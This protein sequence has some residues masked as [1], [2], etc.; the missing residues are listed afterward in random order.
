MRPSLVTYPSETPLRPC[1]RFKRYQQK[2][3]QDYSE[4]PDKEEGSNY[5]SAINPG[6]FTGSPERELLRR[7]QD[8]CIDGRLVCPGIQ[9]AAD[10]YISALNHAYMKGV[11]I[12]NVLKTRSTR[13]VTT[14]P[15]AREYVEETCTEGTSPSTPLPVS[16]CCNVFMPTVRRISPQIARCGPFMRHSEM[17][18]EPTPIKR[19]RP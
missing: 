3:W 11:P 10:A 12:T 8:S 14:Y 2:D 16:T 17:H 1:P 4:C 5:V 9:A 19:F 7:P 6:I 15:A 13:S 18:W